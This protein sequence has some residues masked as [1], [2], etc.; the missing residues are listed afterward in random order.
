MGSAST[1]ELSMHM[2]IL[3]ATLFLN[4]FVHGIHALLITPPSSTR[5]YRQLASLI[6]NTFDAPTVDLAARASSNQQQRQ[7][8]IEALW[9]NMFEKSLTEELTFKQYCL[10]AR[11]MRGTKYCLLVL[12]EYCRDEESDQCECGMMSLG[13]LKWAC[14]SARL[15]AKTQVVNTMQYLMHQRL[16]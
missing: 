5:D 12:K 3:C 13:L 9:W 11:R 10:T 8:K 15:A 1:K 2:H 7:S 6:A 14:H 4:A 16:S